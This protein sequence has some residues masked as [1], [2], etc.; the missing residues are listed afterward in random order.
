M[1]VKKEITRATPK[2]TN[3]LTAMPDTGKNMVRRIPGQGGWG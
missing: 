1:A 2:A 3:G